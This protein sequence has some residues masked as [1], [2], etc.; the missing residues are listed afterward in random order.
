MIENDQ[1]PEIIKAIVFSI[2]DDDG[3]TPKIYFPRDMEESARLLI[4]MKTISILMGDAIY[5]DG[6]STS[7]IN[8]FGILPL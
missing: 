4:A 7:G 5:Q 1:K 3:P 6:S 2:F 8:Y